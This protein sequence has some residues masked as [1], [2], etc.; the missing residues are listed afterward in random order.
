MNKK[1]FL[2]LMAGVDEETTAGGSAAP[3]ADSS[4]S[5]PADP[6]DASVESVNWG[7][8]AE[9]DFDDTSTVEGDIVVNAAPA[10]TEQTAA[11]PADTS[12]SAATE[13][14]A[15]PVVE[16][17]TEPQ[18]AQ[19]VVE[20]PQQFDW[21]KWE[22]E[23]TTQLENEYRL[24]DEE[25]TAML[26]EPETILPKMAA[27]VHARVVKNVL[28]QLPQVI[29]N[30]VPHVLQQQTQEKSQR[31][32]FFSLNNDIADT[33]YATAIQQAGQLFRQLNPNASAEEAAFAVGNMVRASV[34]LPLKVQGA[35]ATEAPAQS[36]PR[37]QPFV[38][39][40]GGG[41]GSVKPAPTNEFVAFAQE[42]IDLDS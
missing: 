10:A 5:N 23:T 9:D 24:T 32:L 34:G 25:A 26:T 38:P 37:T 17:K 18:A 22:S 30:L 6:L 42:L 29:A 2:R 21:A 13:V 40:Q 4:S 33:K 16:T 3:V 7:G 39:A 19:P 31:E 27:S 15:E 12:A 20:E 11:Q 8:M 28:Q 41:G 14:K 36:Q 1:W 35:Q